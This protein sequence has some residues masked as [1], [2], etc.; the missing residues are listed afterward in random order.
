MCVEEGGEGGGEKAW[1][2]TECPVRVGTGESVMLGRRE[3][4]CSS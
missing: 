3:Q 1:K 2:D 4:S